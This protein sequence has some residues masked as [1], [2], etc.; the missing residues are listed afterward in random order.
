MTDKSCQDELTYLEQYG[1]DT[2]GSGYLKG[3]EC[4]DDGTYKL[5]QCDELGSVA[6]DIL[7]FFPRLMVENEA[8]FLSWRMDI[9]FPAIYC[10][11]A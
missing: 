3:P 7:E 9:A 5:K 11:Y 10:A 2:F 1:E 8:G 4:N 6:I